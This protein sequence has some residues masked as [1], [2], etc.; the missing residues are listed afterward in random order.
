[1]SKAVVIL[2]AAASCVFAQFRVEP[3]AAPPSQLA[4]NFSGPLSKTGV[5][6]VKSDG[7]VYCEMWFVS[8][9]PAG[10]ATTEQS[11]SLT[12]IPLG[13]LLG[14]IQF[15]GQGSDRRGQTLNPGLYT[16]RYGNYPVNGDHQGV[17]PQRDFLVLSPVAADTA[18]APVQGFEPL[19]DLSRKASRSPHPAVLSMWKA[20]SAS[21][22]NLHKEGETDWVLNIKI[23]DTPVAIVVIGKVEG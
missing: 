3:A 5:K 2:L 20:D 13:A 23:G 11:V 8:T 18:P 19:M 6:I 4:A 1:M 14:V 7:S 12:T 22:P 17:A 10:P 21:A 16:M 15:P 9:M